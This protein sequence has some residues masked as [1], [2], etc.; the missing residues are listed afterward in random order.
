MVQILGRRVLQIRRS[1]CK[2]KKFENR[3]RRSLRRYA[4]KHKNGKEWPAWYFDNG[5][6]HERPNHFPNSQPHPT[7]QDYDRDWDAEID[8]QGP[9]GLLIESLVWSGLKIDKKIFIWQKKIEADRHPRYPVPAPEVT[10][11]WHG[12]PQQD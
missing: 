10:G 9:V 12:Y 1:C 11:P 7:T 6:E 2:N 5:N 8:P 3:F 4:A